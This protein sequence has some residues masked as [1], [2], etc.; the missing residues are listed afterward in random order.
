[1]PRLLPLLLRD[2]HHPVSQPQTFQMLHKGCSTTTTYVLHLPSQTKHG[3]TLTFKHT[4]LLRCHGT[5]ITFCK[6]RISIEVSRTT[7]NRTHGVH[8][9]PMR[10]GCIE[11]IYSSA[12]H[13]IDSVIYYTRQMV[14]IVTM[15]KGPEG[16]D[17]GMAGQGRG[18]P[19]AVREREESPN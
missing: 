7:D 3:L 13:S 8:S 1:M 12:L 2:L 19:E 16:G 18:C 9:W 6:H 14:E 4:G 10:S 11:L 5:L 17:K 15:Y